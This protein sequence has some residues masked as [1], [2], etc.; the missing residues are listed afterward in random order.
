MSG[1][2]ARRINTAIRFRCYLCAQGA[3]FGR[4]CRSLGNGR[5][6]SNMILQ[7][8]Q[9]MRDGMIEGEILSL[10]MTKD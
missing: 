9:G 2:L 4:N 7:L 1:R 3:A 10:T 8:F 5:V 6:R